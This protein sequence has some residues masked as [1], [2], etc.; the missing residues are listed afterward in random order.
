MVIQVARDSVEGAGRRTFATARRGGERTGQ[1]QAARPRSRRSRDRSRPCSASCAGAP[2]GACVRRRDRAGS[3]RRCRSCADP[4]WCRRAAASR[5]GALA[6][7]RRADSG[8]CSSTSTPRSA[9]AMRASA[10]GIVHECTAAAVVEQVDD[11]QRLVH[12]HQRLD[13]RRAMSPRTSAR[14]VASFSLSR[15]VTS[16]KSPSAVRIGALADALDQPLVLAAVVDQVGDGTDLA[17]RACARRST[18]SGRRAIEPSS[19]MIS[20]STA[21]GENPASRARSQHAS[22]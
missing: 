13:A 19:F 8:R 14:C 4:S 11:R 7:A 6:Q 21:A 16:R 20:H 5:D 15:K 17:G 10:A 9:R 1:P 2:A 12:A 3:A 18:R 22:V